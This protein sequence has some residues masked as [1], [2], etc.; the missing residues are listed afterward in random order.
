MELSP[1]NSYHWWKY[2][3]NVYLFI[4]GLP[5]DYWDGWGGGGCWD[6]L[7]WVGYWDGWGGCGCWDGWVCCLDAL[8]GVVCW[9]PLVGR[10]CWASLNWAI[11]ISIAFG[12]ALLLCPICLQIQQVLCKPPFLSLVSSLLISH[13]SNLLFSS[14]CLVKF[15]LRGVRHQ[16]MEL[17]PINSDHWWEILWKCISLH[18]WTS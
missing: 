14:V 5:K 7:V 15:S 11:W 10:C 18:K 2:Y 1:I 8:M 6:G 9:D 12:Q 4:S 13:C 16:G 3:G 17:S